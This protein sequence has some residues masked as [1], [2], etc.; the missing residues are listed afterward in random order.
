MQF[1]RTSEGMY[2]II[3]YDA[4]EKSCTTFFAN[5]LLTNDDKT[6]IYDVAKNATMS[7]KMNA[8]SIKLKITLK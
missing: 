6:E 4:K 7:I 3:T 5:D 2:V 8:K 1:H